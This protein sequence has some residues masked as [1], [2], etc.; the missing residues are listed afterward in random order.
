VAV[1]PLTPE[2]GAITYERIVA[3]GAWGHAPYFGDAE[4]PG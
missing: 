4:R 3:V 1:F 2:A